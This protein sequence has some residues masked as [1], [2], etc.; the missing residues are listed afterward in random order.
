MKNCEISEAARDA[1]RAYQRS[2]YRQNAE[3][4]CA[5]QRQWRRANPERVKE[6]ERLRWERLAEKAQQA[7]QA[8][9]AV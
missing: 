1:R 7:E 3:K 6:Y 8:A 5:Y 4:L 9:A 2:Y